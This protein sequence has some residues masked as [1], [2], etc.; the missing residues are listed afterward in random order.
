MLNKQAGR[1]AEAQA[2]LEPLI[3]PNY[4]RPPILK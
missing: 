1:G 3:F 2:E 4:H